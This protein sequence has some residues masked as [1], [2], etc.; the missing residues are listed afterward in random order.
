MIEVLTI[1]VGQAGI[2]L[3]SAILEQYCAEHGI[4]H[5]GKRKESSGKDDSF[6]VF[7]EETCSGQFVP[8]KLVVKYSIWL[9]WKEDAAN[10][11]ARGHYTIGKQVI[12]K[13]NDRLR[14]LVDHCD[15]VM[16]FVIGHSVGGGTGSGLGA[17]IL[18]RLA[19][20]Y[21]KKTKIGFEIYQSPNL[22]TC[23]VE[24][25][26]ELLATHW[27]LDHTEVSLL[28]DNEAIYGIY[29]KQLRIAKPDL[30]NLNKLI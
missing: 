10:N 20:D 27:L 28:L 26:N 5:N 21:R 25:Y 24:P 16:G 8:R 3:G 7:F 19:V 9:N 14:K 12:D 23:V 29:Q 15:N 13:I 6:K 18:E 4:D 22:S 11:F 1:E 30:D 2:Q 17:L